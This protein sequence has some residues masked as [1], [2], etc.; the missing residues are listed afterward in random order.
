[1]DIFTQGIAG[2]VLAQLGAK[3]DHRRYATFSGFAAGLLPDADILIRSSGDPLLT[4]E[5]HRQFSHSLLFIPIGALLACIILLPLMYRRLPVGWLYLY[6]LLG[7][8]S[9]GLL[10]ACTSYGTQLLWPFSD[11]RIAWNLVAVVD[12]LFTLVLVVMLAIG[13]WTRKRLYAASAVIFAMLY[14]AL[15][16]YQ[17]QTAQQLQSELAS[18]RGHKIERSVIKPTLGNILL[19]RS[20]Y[21]YDGHYYIDAIRV[22]ILA[23]NKTYPG[24]A[25]SQFMPD[26]ADFQPQPSTVQ[27]R[28]IQ[29]FDKLSEG[30]LVIHP[31]D[32]LVIGDVRYAML[33]N[34]THPLWGIRLHPERPMQHASEALFRKSDKH[35]RQR[36]IDMLMGRSA[37]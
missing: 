17:Q 36:F 31:E 37:D 22:G 12:P 21:Q 19:W 10:D 14:L 26:K 1:M 35:T 24:S 6:C 13:W 29:R 34:S 28:D 33:P 25:I 32:S 30:Y 8:S 7:Y 16:F 27:Y 11:I 20:I 3:Q 4:L 18:Q 2:A 9:A 15:A 5:F 23:E